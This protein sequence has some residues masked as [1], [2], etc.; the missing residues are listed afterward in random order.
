MPATCPAILL[1][2]NEAIYT[3]G[4][5]AEWD[6]L[7]LHEI[8]DSATRERQTITDENLGIS[9]Y[10]G[11]KLLSASYVVDCHTRAA[12]GIANYHPG[13]Q[14]TPDVLGTLFEDLPFHLSKNIG[15][16]V[17]SQ[18][19]RQRPAGDFHH[20]NFQIDHLFPE[21][22]VL[23]ASRPS[24]PDHDGSPIVLNPD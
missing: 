18:P 14:I 24:D 8:T 6:H 16:F 2:S 10:E 19:R 9:V 17:F 11:Y 21:G 22:D 23:T 15:T 13:W 7:W 3:F 20:V 4:L 1:H 12:R 5:A